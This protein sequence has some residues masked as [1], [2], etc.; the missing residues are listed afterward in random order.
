M[1]KIYWAALIM[2]PFFV[3]GQSWQ[4]KFEQL[5]SNLPTPN[6]YRTASGRP[7]PAYWQ[8][9][10]DYTIAVN[11]DEDDL[12]LSGSEKVV[13]HNNSPQTLK[14]LWFQLD[15]NVRSKGSLAWQTETNEITGD[16]EAEQMMGITDERFYEGGYFIEAVTDLNNLPMKYT[17]NQTMMRVDLSKPLA[18]GQSVSVKIKWHYNLYDRLTVDG[19]GGYEYFPK[20]D[21]YL[22]TVAQWYPR[23]AVYDD[24]E[25]WQNKQFIGAGEFALSFGDFDVTI[26]APEDHIVAATG[27]IQNI[28]EVLSETQ[29]KRYEKAIASTEPV[30][31][32]TEKEARKA[33]KTKSSGLKAWHYKA[34]NVRDF[35]FASS[36]KF[37][38][39]AM[40]V[41]LESTSPIAMS[42]YP[43]EGNPL[44]EE[45]STVAV[46]NALKTYS[47][48]TFDYPYPVAIS[49]H[50]AN[51]GMEYPMIC[52]NMG[53]PESEGKYSKWKLYDMV[54]VIV[55][56]V[57]HNYFPMIV[58]T[59]ERQWTWQDEGI[60]TFLEQLT[61]DEHYPEFELTWGKP[62]SVTQ[63]MRG[64]PDYIRPLMTNSEQLAQFGFNGYGKPSAALC[65]LRDVVMGPELFDYSFRTYARSWAFKGPTPAD[66]FRI[67]ED[68]SAVDLD[69]FWR[70][71]FYSIDYVDI[72]LTGINWF[73][74][75]ES[76]DSNE[77]PDIPE[78][79]KNNLLGEPIP[80]YLE[81]AKDSEY[82]EFRNRIDNQLIINSNK[83]KYLYELHFA[84]LGGLVSPIILQWQYDDG[85]LESEILPAEIWRLNEEKISKVFLKEKKVVSIIVDPDEKT[86][87]AY[88]FNNAFPRIP[89]SSRFK[90]FINKQD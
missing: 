10:V 20:D 85:S 8:Q 43:K 62:E 89:E 86:G 36:R 73:V 45:Y 5:G 44:W 9:K 11:L 7:G 29:L 26:T 72:D 27:E 61:M 25:G 71:W 19:R 35:A 57:G 68:A 1:L 54:A 53:R 24:V 21:N 40:K 16:M 56:E 69:W 47:R 88:L 22:F 34:S 79:A 30:F 76:K 2:L 12:V 48:M 31:I 46:A 84:N 13:L 67:M 55:H 37:I 87:D 18:S 50:S 82:Q 66:F 49:V 80:L 38:W 64:D 51:Q 78:E 83:E 90:E 33:E 75:K 3:N 70:G 74:I 63:Y 23:M 28:N 6:S 65:V 60:N 14:Y 4:G 32:V 52:F 58:N 81:E 17:I 39:D 59:D 15:Q 42:F 77:L 41:D